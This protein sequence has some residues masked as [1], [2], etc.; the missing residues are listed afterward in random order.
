MGM[1][2]NNSGMLVINIEN[3]LII[4]E[5]CFYDAGIISPKTSGTILNIKGDVNFLGGAFDFNRSKDAMS[6]INMC[7]NSTASRW[8]QKTSCE[9]TL[10]NVNITHGAEI[11]L[12]GERMGEVA[13]GR[14]V[15]VMSN[16]QLMC[17]N[18]PVCGEGSFTLQDKATLGIGSWQG[19]NSQVNTGNILTAERRFH[20]GANYCYY[21]GETPQ[22]TGRFTTYPAANTVRTIILNKEKTS[23]VLLVAQDMNVM[24]QIKVNRGIIDQSRNKLNLPRI[25][26]KQ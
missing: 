1:A 21:A 16:A 3:D 18:H 13:K 11:V 24:E 17:D 25:S 14:T 4:E 7:G 23:Q 20:S 9:V 10:C 19:I 26:E 22:S 5:G 2:G 12:R 6:E 8:T 15:T